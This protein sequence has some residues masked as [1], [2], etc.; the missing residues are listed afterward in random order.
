MPQDEIVSALIGLV[1]ACDHNPKTEHT[2]ALILQALTFDG[3]PE[4]V[5]TMADAIRAEKFAIS[6]GCAACATPC[7]NTADYDMQRLYTAPE[8]T[9]RAKLALLQTLCAIAAARKSPVLPPAHME[10][11]YKALAFVGYDID[12]CYLTTLLK[13]MQ[14]LC[15]AGS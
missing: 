9:K 4:Q 7:G 2:D 15:C 8:E 13:E 11:I 3:P 6:P 14:A 1:G 12:P 10:L 5:Q